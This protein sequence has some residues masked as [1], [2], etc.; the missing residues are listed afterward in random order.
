M[1]AKVEK[2]NRSL[3]LGVNYPLFSWCLLGLTKKMERQSSNV[4][5]KSYTLNTSQFQF[6]L[7]Y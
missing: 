7:I 6:T 4:T 5:G 2:R 1:G 3:S